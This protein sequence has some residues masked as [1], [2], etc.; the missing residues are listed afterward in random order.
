MHWSKI[1]WQ[2]FQYTNSSRLKFIPKYSYI[3]K[4]KICVYYIFTT[5]PVMSGHKI[6]CIRTWKDMTVGVLERA[7]NKVFKSFLKMLAKWYQGLD[8]YDSNL[9]S[10]VQLQ[11]RKKLENCSLK[12]HIMSPYKM[13]Y[14]KNCR[15]RGWKPKENNSGAPCS[16]LVVSP[17]SLAFSRFLTAWMNLNLSIYACCISSTEFDPEIS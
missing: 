10:I 8:S 4:H 9:P 1:L 5:P 6:F 13:W 15:D 17:E 16:A 12:C 7:T 3:R 14:F 2:V 11:L